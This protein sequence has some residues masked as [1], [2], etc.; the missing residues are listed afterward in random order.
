MD[1][2]QENTSDIYFMSDVHKTG[3][4]RW[5][6]ARE[7]QHVPNINVICELDS[8]QEFVC[9]IYLFCNINSMQRHPKLD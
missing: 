1:F 3:T 6:D 4:S 5:K 9:N 7:I 2:V 8:V